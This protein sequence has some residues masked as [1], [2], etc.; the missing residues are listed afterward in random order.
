LQTLNTG[1]PAALEIYNPNFE[2]YFHELV[3]PLF[4]EKGEVTGSVVVVRDVTQQRR[5]EE[6]LILTDRLASI[7][8]LSSGIAHELNNPLTSVIG[9]SQL[10]MQGDVPDNIKEDLGIIYSEAQRAAVIVKNLLTF[11]RKHAPVTQLSQVNIVI[12]DVLRLRAYEQKVNN[13][14][15]EKHLAA[16]LP[17]IMMDPF[18]I[19]Q[20]FLNII[21]N[22][23][24]AML[25]AHQKGKLV[26]TTARADGVIRITFTDD[27]P[28]ITEANQKRIFNPFFTTKEVGKGT[29]L[30]LS[31]CHGIITE[32]GG[33]IYVRSTL[34]QGTTFT[35]ELPLNG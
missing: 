4:N 18:Q 20:V 24:F 27:G 19:Q 10:L 5:M 28:G 17:E 26:I 3:S 9:F 22:A 7:G 11:A 8:E 14:E 2:A 21:V 12:E 23:E 6:Q 29:G 33:K 35:V 32:H 15:I 16:N 31:I 25:E 1:K 30:G 13:V 34:G